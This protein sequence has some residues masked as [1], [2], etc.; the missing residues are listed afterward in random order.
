M[1]LNRILPLVLSAFV[2][3]DTVDAAAN[4]K[5]LDRSKAAK[6]LKKHIDADTEKLEQHKFAIANAMRDNEAKIIKESL[7]VL[8]ESKESE[9]TYITYI[10]DKLFPFGPAGNAILATTYI[11]G[12]PNF[13]LALIPANINVSS[14]SLLVSFAVGGLLG[15]VFMHL[16]PETFTGQG[17]DLTVEGDEYILIDNRKNVFLGIGMFIGFLLFFFIDKLMRILEGSDGDSE[18]SHIHSHSH[19]QSSDQTHSSEIAESATSSGT[20]NQVDGELK[21]RGVKNAEKD[22]DNEI[23]ESNVVISNP[24]ASVKTSA[25]LNLISDFT[26]NITDGLAI[27]SSFYISKNVGCTTAIATFMHEIPH[28]VGDFA[29]LIQGGFTKWQAMGSQFITALGAYLGTFIGIALQMS[30]ENNAES[31]VQ[32]VDDIGLFGTSLSLGDMTLPF[33]AGGFL[34]IA[35]SV[36]P[37]LLQ[38][39]HKASRKDELMKFGMQLVCMFLGIGF[40]AII[41]LNEDD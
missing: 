39:D 2:F 8:N 24:N 17:V 29:L 26:H 21:K 34:Y 31:T 7:K 38:T 33:T 12:P 19:I 30:I 10:F 6:Y 28:E 23:G 5:V 4:G 18:H 37:E 15:D 11:S 25:Y 22:V 35:F 9:K 20:N 36:I 41:A 16:L 40:M 14:L 1:K 13:I 32:G 3:F 27:A